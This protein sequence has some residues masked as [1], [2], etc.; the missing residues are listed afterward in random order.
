MRPVAI[1]N[2]LGGSDLNVAAMLVVLFNTD[3]GALIEK[4]RRPFLRWL[5]IAR[6][7]V[8]AESL[9]AMPRPL[10]AILCERFGAQLTR[11]LDDRI[12][13]RPGVDL[14]QALLAG[15]DPS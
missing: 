5:E 2:D 8:A 13:G 4:R 7:V 12:D 14:Y 1:E 6:G 9:R 3:A 10:G 15:S 11:A